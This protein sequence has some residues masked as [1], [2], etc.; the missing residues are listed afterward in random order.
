[1]I[2]H[3]LDLDLSRCG[4][5]NER[6]GCRV[7][8]CTGGVRNIVEQCDACGFTVLVDG[9][10]RCELVAPI[11]IQ[12]EHLGYVG[13]AEGFCDKQRRIVDRAN[14]PLMVG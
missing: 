7:V 10:A 1:M 3:P 12:I 14:G 13:G 6:N 2:C 9:I 11:H 5:T 8:T 4:S